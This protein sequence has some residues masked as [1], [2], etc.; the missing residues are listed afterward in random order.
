MKDTKL[1]S[2]TH[3]NRTA[4]KPATRLEHRIRAAEA[5]LWAEYDITVRESFADLAD[6]GLR[7]R[8]LSAGAGQDLILLHGS[9]MTSACWAPLLPELAGYRVHMV[10]LPGHGLSAPFRYRRGQ[11]RAHGVT[12][13]DDLLSVLGLG[14]VPVIGH[15]VGGMYA[16]WHAAARPGRI[17]SLIL[18]GPGGTL[19]GMRVRAPL[20]LMTLPVLGTAM[21]RMPSPRTAYR[22]LMTRGQGSAL[23]AASNDLLDAMRFAARQPESAASIASLHHTL[24]R[25]RAPAPEAIMTSSELAQV[26]VPTLFLW[27]RDDPYMSPATAR[28]SV[29]KIEGAVLREVPGGH[30]PWLDDPAAYAKPITEFVASAKSA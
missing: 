5:T 15:S 17:S 16:L 25:F 29:A 3:P 10:D 21:L 30:A 22:S 23:P 7:L 18:A 1:M 27:G 14:A 24:D 13:V 28:P 19:P 26:S 2:T 12:L 11:A 8:V 4:D 9:V 20:S 6:S